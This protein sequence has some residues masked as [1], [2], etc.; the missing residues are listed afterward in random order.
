MQI[1]ME[2]FLFICVLFFL[3]YKGAL[4]YGHFLIN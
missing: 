2:P 3:F 4:K 1:R